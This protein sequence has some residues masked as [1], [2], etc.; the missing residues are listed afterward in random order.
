MLEGIDSEKQSDRVDESRKTAVTMT[1]ISQVK[2]FSHEWCFWK[3]I[4]LHECSLRHSWTVFFF[5]G[6]PLMECC[7][8]DDTSPENTIVGLPPGWVDTDISRLYTWASI[9]LS[10]MIVR[11]TVICCTSVSPNLLYSVQCLSLVCYI[12]RESK[13]TRNVLWS[14]A[15]VCLCV[16]PRPHAHSPHYCT[17]PRM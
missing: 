9:P 4:A 3:K 1:Q 2:T 10:Q 12:S 16:C 11:T 8:V 17:D 14:R 6:V 13:T 15:S 7:R 5:T